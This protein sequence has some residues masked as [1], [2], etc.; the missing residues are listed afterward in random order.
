MKDKK[1]EK[2]GI[3]SGFRKKFCASDTKK[4]DEA[5][6]AELLCE[7]DKNRIVPFHMPGHKRADFDF[8]NGAQKIDITEIE[9]FD[10]LNDANGI[11]LQSEKL[12]AEVFGAKQARFLVNGSTGGVLAAIRTVCNA[13]DKVLIARNC[14]KSVYNAVEVFG[15]IPVYVMPSYF[16]EYGF[17]GS[18]FPCDVKKAFEQNPDIKLVVITS[19]T[20][21]G[22]VS[23]VKSITDICRKNGAI[24]FV[25]EA[26]GAHMGLYKKFGES[27]RSLGADIVV[28]SLHKTLP[29]LTQTALLCVCSDRVDA[30][31][32]DR[33]LAIFQSSSPSYVLMAS[34]DGCVRTLKNDGAKL[35]SEWNK[36]IDDCK[37]SLERLKKLSIFQPK[38]DSRVF[39]YDKSKFVVLCT[40]GAISGVELKKVLRNAYDIELEMASVN[41]AIAMS[42]A[43]DSKENFSALESA[44][45]AIDDTLASRNGLTT[46]VLPSLPKKVFEPY[47]TRTLSGEYVDLDKSAGRVS[48]ENVWAYPPGSPVI[49]KGETVCQEDI[50]N[51]TLMYESG[52]NVSSEKRE[53]PTSLYVAKSE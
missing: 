31:E 19:P 5:S 9:G 51:L 7:H 33:N 30:T 10:N 22:I 2:R 11:I 43:G 35:L 38:K 46:S 39:A 44:L 3:F 49:V 18:V 20:Y 42:G 40:G 17:Y 8:L 28:N 48:L 4:H 1:T 34:I 12:A 13:G 16:E 29:S 25:D 15:L 52:V 21:E 47:Q 45:F 36:N 27:A 53:F 14:H 37:K 32:L 50:K 6:L 26:H 23:D 41:Y 24:L